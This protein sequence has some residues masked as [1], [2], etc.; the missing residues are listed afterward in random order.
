MLLITVD[1]ACTVNLQK[2]TT[3]VSKTD[4]LFV[5]C[6][7]YTLWPHLRALLLGKQLL[8]SKLLNIVLKLLFYRDLLATLLNDRY[9]VPRAPIDHVACVNQVTIG[10]S[11]GID[12]GVGTSVRQ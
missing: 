3:N 9:R 7:F 11:L 12:C 1:F 10:A 8:S 4:L 6:P 5:C 2:S